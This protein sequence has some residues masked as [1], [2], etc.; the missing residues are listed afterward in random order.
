MLSK[1][2]HGK[3]VRRWSNLTAVTTEAEPPLLDDPLGQLEHWVLGLPWVKRAVTLAGDERIRGF[4]VV[5]PPLGCHSIWLSIGVEEDAQ[6]GFDVHVVLTRPLAHRG[7]AVGWAEPLLDLSP[8]RVIVGVATPT[9]PRELSAL[10][11]LL[12]VAYNAAFHADSESA[13]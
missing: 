13:R 5:C 7:V 2:S 1:R 10:Q 8:D 12:M 11:S 9:T 4:A 3:L 6:E